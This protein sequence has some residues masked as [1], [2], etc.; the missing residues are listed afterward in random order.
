[1]MNNSRA[2]IF[3]QI[4]LEMMNF[5]EAFDFMD[6]FPDISSNFYSRWAS[7]VARRTSALAPRTTAAAKAAAV[8]MSTTLVLA[9]NLF[10]WL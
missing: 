1:M 9:E 5:R 3:L 2:M 7:G 6:K 8:A 4:S 10:E